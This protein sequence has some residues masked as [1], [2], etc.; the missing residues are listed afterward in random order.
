MIY[1]SALRLADPSSPTDTHPFTGAGGGAGGAYTASPSASDTTG[2][3]G[4][5]TPLSRFVP[6][7]GPPPDATGG[8][9]TLVNQPT[10]TAPATGGVV[11]PPSGGDTSGAGTAGGDAS[12]GSSVTDVAAAIGSLF[13]SIAGTSGGASAQPQVLYQPPANV[14]ST[15][16]SPVVLV[17]ML[18]AVVGTVYY[19]V[20]RKPKESHAG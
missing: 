3:T 5:T 10:I 13:N 18:A 19:L 9:V 1:P 14:T 12:G 17:G 16:V 2:S 6:P 7:S 8:G 11:L 15:G 20:N 4:S